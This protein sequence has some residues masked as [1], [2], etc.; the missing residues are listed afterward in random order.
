MSS[1]GQHKTVLVVSQV[2]VP[3]PASVGQHVADV[4]LNW[5]GEAN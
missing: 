5:P 2:F 3:D 1:I 4:G